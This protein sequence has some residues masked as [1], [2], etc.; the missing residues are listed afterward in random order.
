MAAST[1]FQERLRS[2]GTGKAKGD[3]VEVV[4]GQEDINVTGTSSGADWDGAGHLLTKEYNTGSSIDTPYGLVLVSMG[5]QAHIQQSLTSQ[6]TI[7]FNGEMWVNDDPSIAQDTA[8]GEESY[9]IDNRLTTP[10]N[11]RNAIGSG[12]HTLGNTST[13]GVVNDILSPYYKTESYANEPM[14]HIFLGNT[15]DLNL[16]HYLNGNSSTAQTNVSVTGKWVFKKVKI[17]KNAYLEKL[18]MRAY[19]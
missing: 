12:G 3:F 5:I 19:G 8:L 2:V 17:T 9:T 18:A 10:I 4:F 13:S 1:I 16:K 7:L 11:A 14:Q 15:I 6:Q